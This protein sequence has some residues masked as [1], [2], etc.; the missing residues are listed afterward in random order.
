MNFSKS[1]NMKWVFILY[2]MTSTLLTL[3][4]AF[5]GWMYFSELL[6][7][8]HLW[9]VYVILLIFIGMA[10]GYIAAQKFQ[11]KID[12]L[13][14]GFM[15]LTKGNLSVRLPIQG[16]DSFDRIYLDF[17]EMTRSLEDRMKLLQSLGEENVLLQAKS[18]EDAVLEERKRL[19]RDLHDSVSQQLFA[20]HMASSSLP[21]IVDSNLEKAKE[22]ME[23]LIQMSFMAQK[24]MRALIAQLRPIEL[25]GKSIVEA[26]DKWFPDYC[27]QNALQGNL[28]V[29]LKSE[30]SEAKEHQLFLIIQ[31][32]VANIVKHASAKHVK[33]SLFE[34]EAQYVL[35]IVDDGKGFDKKVK[36]TGSYGLSTMQERAMKLGGDVEILSKSGHGTR[37][38][39][40]IPKFK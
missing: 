35:S 34:T 12:T 14:L 7:Q 40:H 16:L 15:Q 37:I 38:K 1:K 29:Q 39:A 19:A 21:K 8:S 5:L 20:I 28:D 3:G 30:L 17:N 13:H 32:A 18:N 36:K 10:V 27:K 9:V 26:L 11:R 31:E 25:D 2:F 24:Q 22:V 33:L 23:Q 6:I 4:A